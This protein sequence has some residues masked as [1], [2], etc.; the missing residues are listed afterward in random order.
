MLFNLISDAPDNFQ[1]SGFSWVDLNFLADMAD[2]YSH[3]VVR[4]DGF[5]VPDPVSYTHL[6]VYKRQLK[7]VD[8]SLERKILRVKNC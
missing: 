6:D 4:T 7:Q 5:L 3:C 2:V 1:I 8:I